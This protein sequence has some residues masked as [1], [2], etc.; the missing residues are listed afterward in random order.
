MN[1]AAT[2]V[3]FAYLGDEAMDAAMVEARLGFMERQ[4]Q[5]L[6]ALIAPSARRIDVIVPYVAP[7]AW[8]G[9]V[10]R[11]VKRHGFRLDEASIDAER[12]NRFEYP[13]FRAMKALAGQASPDHLLYYC[14]SKGIFDLDERKMGLFRLHSQVGLTAPLDRLAGDQGVTRAGL[15]PCRYGWCWYNFFWIKAGYM[16]GLAVEESA[17]RHDFE[18]LI[19]DRSDPEGFRGVLSLADQ[20]PC[21]DL[22]LAVRPWYRPEEL[23][24]P[25]LCAA[26]DAYA[27]ME[28]PPYAIE[29]A[30]TSRVEN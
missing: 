25:G 9:E 8:D 17:H 16:A 28:A 6:A 23:A 24:A 1:A 3:Y 21:A 29:A 19:G 27:L 4:L 13:G 2:V 15:F 12:V 22:G 14:H 10:D 7:R 18:A 30:L 5:W 20:L 11:A 26:Y